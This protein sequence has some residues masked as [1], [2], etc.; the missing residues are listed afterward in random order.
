MR[1]YPAI[2][3]GIY[4]IQYQRYIYSGFV[5]LADYGIPTILD[6]LVTADELILEDLIDYL[7]TYL[8]ENHSDDLKQNFANLYQIVFEHDSFTKLHDFCTTFA[9]SKPEAI[10]KSNDFN[11]LKKSLLLSILKRDD[12]DLKEIEIFD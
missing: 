6:F 3:I 7:Q 1:I 4:S 2:L 9:A 10:F 5:N 8:I 11:S 12:L